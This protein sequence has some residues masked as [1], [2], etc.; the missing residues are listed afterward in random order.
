MKKLILALTLL[1]L[2]P[3]CASIYST[4]RNPASERERE[5]GADG[6]GGDIPE[7]PLVNNLELEKAISLLPEMLWKV[8]S[9]HEL[10]ANDN[11][12]RYWR[13][14]LEKDPTGFADRRE[15][16]ESPALRRAYKKL[17][18]AQ[19]KNVFAELK[20]IKFVPRKSGPCQDRYHFHKDA[21]AFN[22]D[23]SEICFSTERLK[24]KLRLDNMALELIAL[25]GHELTHRLGGDE[26]E[27]LALQKAI[28]FTLDETDLT[29]LKAMMETERSLGRPRLDLVGNL[30]DKT[31]DTNS[32]PSLCYY[33]AGYQAEVRAT[34]H[35]VTEKLNHGFSLARLR[36][37]RALIAADMQASPLGGFCS[38]DRNSVNVVH[39]Y[40]HQFKPGEPYDLSSQG[41]MMI[42]V[43]EKGHLMMFGF[44][45]DET[46]L[47][48]N[49]EQSNRSLEIFRANLFQ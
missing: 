21:S 34:M 23:P 12:I 16:A 29:S 46:A 39:Y 35:L 8:M 45:R 20:T 42:P 48:F 5:G 4:A 44:S 10:M 31:G 47:K 14:R 13:I 30:L 33:L 2:L 36:G 40:G 7:S 11:E 26:E 38:S 17:F 43:I 25:A 18:P 27:A 3:A 24:E 49:F 6:G 1:S 28:R 22:Q 9:F 19:G 15:T 32:L 37:L 41:Q